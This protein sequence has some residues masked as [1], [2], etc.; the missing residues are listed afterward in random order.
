ML[1]ATSSPAGIKEAGHS[2]FPESHAQF[3]EGALWLAS[4]RPVGRPMAWNPKTA[5]SERHS[6]LTKV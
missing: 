4:S 5:L 3:P 6:G 2:G 1:V